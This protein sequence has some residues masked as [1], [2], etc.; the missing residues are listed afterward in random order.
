VALC[1]FW[2][3][4]PKPSA[5]TNAAPGGETEAI[6]LAKQSLELMRN[7]KPD[8]AL[9]VSKQAADLA[10]ATPQDQASLLIALQIRGIIMAATN[11]LQDAERLAAEADSRQ[12]PPM[13]GKQVRS[14]VASARCDFDTASALQLEIQAVGQLTSI[15]PVLNNLA[16]L[17]FSEGRYSRARERLEYSRSLPNTGDTMEVGWNDSAR[18]ALAAAYL[19][20]GMLAESRALVDKN[21]GLSRIDGMLSDAKWALRDQGNLYYSLQSLIGGIVWLHANDLDDRIPPFREVLEQ[22]LAAYENDDSPCRVKF[23]KPIETEPAGIRLLV[24]GEP[25]VA[26][27]ASQ[28]AAP[29]PKDR[30]NDGIPDS[31]DACPDQAEVVNAIDDEDG[32]PDEAPGRVVG[33]EVHLREALPFGTNSATIDQRGAATLD[34]LAKFL[35]SYPALV[36]TIDGHTDD[37]GEDSFNLELS[38]RRAAAVVAAMEERGISRSR[39]GSAGYGETQPKVPGTDPRA[40]AANRRVEITVRHDGS[41]T[42]VAAKTAA[43]ESAGTPKAVIAPEPAEAIPS[44]EQARLAVMAYCKARQHEDDCKRG[45]SSVRL[46]FDGQSTPC[47]GGVKDKGDGTFAFDADCPGEGVN[48]VVRW[49]G[50]AWSVDSV[51]YWMDPSLAEPA[52]PVAA[53]SPE[54]ARRLIVA[55]C[56]QRKSDSQCRDGIDFYNMPVSEM[57]DACSTHVSKDKDGTLKVD[58]G[59]PCGGVNGRME[60]RAGAWQVVAVQ[61]YPGGC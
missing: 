34:W 29:A 22:T 26:E 13:V 52:T 27:T 23:S 3:G 33:R 59:C 45:F 40:R 12:L 60:L 24:K 44:N 35:Q 41:P 38:K 61:Y 16:R 2:G 32:C 57:P 36:M 31:R 20:L 5:P 9:R 21:E 17:D 50:G 55:Y 8:E 54:Q 14:S 4:C 49:R 39:L 43:M 15:K 48:A 6:R 51:R 1:I 56:A 11:R 53:P 18:L 10:R 19:R 37:V 30:D 7:S 47:V 46:P 42:G 58:A 25:A 28:S